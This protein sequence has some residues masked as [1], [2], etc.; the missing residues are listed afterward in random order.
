MQLSKQET[1][2]GWRIWRNS[3]RGPWWARREAPPN[4]T[5]KQIDAGLQATLSHDDLDVLRKLID[6]Q[7]QLE[8]ELGADP[9]AS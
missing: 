3:E 8:A 6:D 7:K 4:F 1:P 9:G 2:E 5:N